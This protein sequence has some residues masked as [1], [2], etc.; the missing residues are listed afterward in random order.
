L[1][2]PIELLLGEPVDDDE[3]AVRELRCRD[4]ASFDEVAHDSSEVSLRLWGE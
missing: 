4:R 2:R 1:L 3:D